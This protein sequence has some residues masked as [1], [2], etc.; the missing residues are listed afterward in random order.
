[1]LGLVYAV[2]CSD[3][4]ARR[5]MLKNVSTSLAAI[6]SGLPAMAFGKQAVLLQYDS[7]TFATLLHCPYSRLE[8]VSSRTGISDACRS[9]ARSVSSGPVEI[10]VLP[11]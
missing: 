1:M 11:Q 9:R 7:R 4:N 8:T 5:Y 6:G 3:L 10:L 2:A